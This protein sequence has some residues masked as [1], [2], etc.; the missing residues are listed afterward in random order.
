VNDVETNLQIVHDSN[1][2][3]GVRQR[4]LAPLLEDDLQLSRRYLA[5]M[6]LDESVPESPRQHLEKKNQRFGRV[7]NAAEPNE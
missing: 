6:K 1:H 2:P 7:R 3:L 4:N 5:E